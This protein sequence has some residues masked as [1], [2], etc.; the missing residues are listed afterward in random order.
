VESGRPS[1]SH[2]LRPPSI[3]AARDPETGRLI[4]EDKFHQGRLYGPQHALA[5][6]EALLALED[7]PAIAGFLPKA[8]ANVPG[9][10]LLAPACDRA[11]GLLQAGAGR[12]REAARALR[13]ALDGFGRRA[14]RSR[15]LA[16]A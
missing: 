1:S 5:L 4:S 6:L 10:A 14:V 15:L 16:L 7:W 12:R 3:S 11:E 8:R 13:R 9:N 2:F